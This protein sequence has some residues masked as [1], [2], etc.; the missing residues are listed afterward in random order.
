[1]TE[2]K[3]AYLILAHADPQM[4]NKLVWVIDYKAFIF[5]HLDKES[6]M[7]DYEELQWPSSCSFIKH[8]TKVYWGGISMINATIYLIKAALDTKETFSHLVLLSGCDYP[9]KHPKIIHQFLN[10]NKNRQFIR[11]SEVSC[12]KPGMRRIS[13]YW[14]HEPFLPLSS[15]IDK[16][17]RT[18]LSKALSALLPPK[19]LKN[20][21]PAFGSQWWALTPDCALYTIR[22]LEDNLDILKFFSTSHAPDELVFHTI[23]ANSPYIQQTEGF[24]KDIKR[25]RTLNNLHIIRVGRVYDEIDFPEIKK[26]DKFFVR[27]LDSGSSEKLIKLINEQ[28]LKD[29]T[30]LSNRHLSS[31]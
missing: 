5:I 4:L 13:D 24:L 10:E 15:K 29:S 14:I 18:L 28:L 23:V 22:F 30:S 6:S 19:K 26:A 21:T 9:I 11:F 12:I 7:S 3:I 2:R 16:P 25:E 1:M 31:T 27:K 8:R 17:F 20:M